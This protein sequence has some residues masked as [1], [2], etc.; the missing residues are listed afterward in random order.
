MI[1]VRL[2]QQREETFADTFD[3]E[4]LTV[5]GDADVDGTATGD[6]REVN[7]QPK[8]SAPAADL[9]VSVA[10]VSYDVENAPDAPAPTYDAKD[11]DQDGDVDFADAIAAGY[12]LDVSAASFPLS[13]FFAKGFDAANNELFNEGHS[14]EA[15]ATADGE[16]RILAH[17]IAN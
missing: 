3:I 16:S 9:I 17:Y 7:Q 6:T 4:T 5:N 12:S 10:D 13:G 2:V 11:L 8:A 15:E 1:N 14:T